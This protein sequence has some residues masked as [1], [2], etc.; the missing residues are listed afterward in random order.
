MLGRLYPKMSFYKEGKPIAKNVSGIDFT[1]YGKELNNKTTKLQYADWVKQKAQEKGYT[2]ESHYDTKYFG[3]AGKEIK[4]PQDLPTD[5][6]NAY[7]EA[8]TN[9]GMS[10]GQFLKGL[11]KLGKVSTQFEGANGSATP[12]T[13]LEGSRLEQSKAGKKGFEG[14]YAP[15][16][17]ADDETE[18]PEQ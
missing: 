4:S 15:G 12:Q 18:P 7:S 11:S 2:V 5:L 9:Y 14:V 17:G 1:T 10:F 3:E 6:Q 13:I 16:E 8:V